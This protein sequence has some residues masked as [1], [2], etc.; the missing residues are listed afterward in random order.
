MGG[1]NARPRDNVRLAMQRGISTTFFVLLFTFAATSAAAMA[2]A[3]DVNPALSAVV[4]L[5]QGGEVRGRIVGFDADGCQVVAGAAREPQTIR[6]DAVQPRAVLALNE[7]LLDKDGTAQEWLEVGRLLHHSPGGGNALSARAFARALKLDPLI[8]GEIDAAKATPRKPDGTTAPAD[9][10]EDGGISLRGG[11]DGGLATSRPAG[12]A[13]RRTRR[14]GGAAADWG[15]E[16]DEQL[17]RS[18]E[19]VKQ[20]AEKKHAVSSARLELYET[21]WA[22]DASRVFEDFAY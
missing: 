9:G 4:P 12:A 1:R 7:R 5:R 17:A 22:G 8:R 21:R 14:G 3:K 2:M 13:T 15:T 11:G 10:V 20:Y 16:S 18:T 19:E 6:W